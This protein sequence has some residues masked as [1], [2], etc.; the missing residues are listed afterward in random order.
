M[1]LLFAILVEVSP[2]AVHAGEIDRLL[3]AVNGKVM[4]EQDLLL[5]RELNA[6]LSD[7]KISVS[8]SR[9]EEISRLID[10]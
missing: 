8:P 10:L 9:T 3:A 7:G 6:F 4:T 2:T 5:A 1:R